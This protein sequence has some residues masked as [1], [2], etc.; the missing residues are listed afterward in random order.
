MLQA[1][2]YRSIYDK[3]ISLQMVTAGLQW[4][5]TEAESNLIQ[6]C[7]KGKLTTMDL[8][9]SFQSFQFAV[10]TLDQCRQTPT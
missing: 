5:I 9:S 8:S 10:H 2:C 6:L 4:S 3:L 7:M 1:S